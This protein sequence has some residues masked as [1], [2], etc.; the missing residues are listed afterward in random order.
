MSA[1]ND[2][3]HQ[4]KMAF[5][6]VANRTGVSIWLRA[7]NAMM[8][9]FLG[10]KGFHPKPEDCKAKT[11]KLGS[12]NGL[13]AS[14]DH[15]P[16]AFPDVGDAQK[17]WRKFKE[18]SITAYGISKEQLAERNHP[19]CATPKCSSL[20]PKY[21]DIELTNKKYFGALKILKD[22]P[23]NELGC[24][25]YIHSDFDLMALFL[26]GP[27]GTSIVSANAG[28]RSRSTLPPGG[29]QRLT[30]DDIRAELNRAFG[31]TV[32]NT[33]IRVNLIQHGHEFEY[34]KG[35]GAAASEEILCFEPEGITTFMSNMNTR[36]PN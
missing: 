25:C 26:R 32:V 4:I 16:E 36:Y 21:Y 2:M 20:L 13:V 8:Y 5:Q 9:T 15:V 1:L 3:P 17:W 30:S 33:E 31:I 34:S 18:S 11:A 23:S 7:P 10:K 29:I 22:H 24:D 19:A 14:P 12:V 28:P 27:H 35:L 6:S